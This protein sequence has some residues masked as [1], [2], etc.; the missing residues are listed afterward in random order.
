MTAH[1][2]TL[3]TVM[4]ATPIKVLAKGPAKDTV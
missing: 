3:G 4:Q 2:S 1:T